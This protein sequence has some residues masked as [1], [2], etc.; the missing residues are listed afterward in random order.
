MKRRQEAARDLHVASDALTFARSGAANPSSRRHDPAAEEQ[1]P[2]G[3]Q[4]T[5]LVIDGNVCSRRALMDLCRLSG[6]GAKKFLGKATPVL[7]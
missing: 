2:E 1:L 3:S 7:V 6:V 5:R 4:K